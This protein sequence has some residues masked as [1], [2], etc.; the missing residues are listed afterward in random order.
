MS[1]C[2]GMSF[3]VRVMVK[4]LSSVSACPVG[5]TTCDLGNLECTGCDSGMSRIGGVCIGNNHPH[6]VLFKQMHK[7]LYTCILVATDI[8]VRPLSSTHTTKYPIQRSG[9]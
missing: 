4:C 9:N 3:I 6:R 8:H 5:C 2:T 7:H 1:Y